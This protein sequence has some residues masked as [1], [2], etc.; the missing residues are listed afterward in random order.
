MRGGRLTAEELAAEGAETPQ[1][2]H[3]GQRE[4]PVG[5]AGKGKRHNGRYKQ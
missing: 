4:T 3:N 2:G 5:M 1:S